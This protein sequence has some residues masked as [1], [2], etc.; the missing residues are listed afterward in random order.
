MYTNLRYR[1]MKKSLWTIL[2]LGL[3][4]FTASGQ[5]NDRFRLKEQHQDTSSV[6]STQLKTKTF[7]NA[8]SAAGQKKKDNIWQKLVF[9]GNASLGF[10][11]YTLIYL[12]PSIGYKINDDLVAGVGFNYQYLKVKA[13]Y[14]PTTT[15]T[16]D[17][18]TDQ[19]YGPK[20]FLNYFFLDQFYVGTQYEVL[21]HNVPIVGPVSGITSYENKWSPVLWIEAGISE[22]L[23]K[24]GYAQIGIR[25]N[26]LYDYESPYASAFF[27]VIG[28][29]F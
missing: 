14:D 6:D 2:L 11:N 26:L 13:Y 24:K 10:G 1:Y 17:G 18:F 28:F 29:Y 5:V 20:F 25:Y 7:G 12:S 9:G 15:K 19:V 21:N 3:A 27:P 4:F 16:Y 22:R 8:D 23:G